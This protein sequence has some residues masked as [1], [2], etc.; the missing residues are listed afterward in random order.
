MN[1]QSEKKFIQFR[2][3]NNDVIILFDKIFYQ[4][5]KSDFDIIISNLHNLYPFND[6]DYDYNKQ[7]TRYIYQNCIIY[8]NYKIASN[9]N[10]LTQDVKLTQDSTKLFNKI[11][12]EYIGELG[13]DFYHELDKNLTYNGTMT[14]NFAK[15]NTIADKL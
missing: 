13:D 5:H 14:L 4:Q 10:K 9:Y 8:F 2:F 3:G 11:Y 12:Y 7:Y 1:T 6:T 15:L